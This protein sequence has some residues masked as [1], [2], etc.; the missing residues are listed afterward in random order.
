MLTFFLRRLLQLCCFSL[1]IMLL[2]RTCPQKFQRHLNL[3][4]RINP[5][6]K[7]LLLKVLMTCDLSSLVIV[8][9]VICQYS[10]SAEALLTL[11][12]WNNCQGTMIFLLLEWKRLC[13]VQDCS[14]IGAM[15]LT[16]CQLWRCLSLELRTVSNGT[17]NAN[18]KQV[19]DPTL[20]AC[21][22]FV[23]G[24]KLLCNEVAGIEAATHKQSGSE[25]WHL[26]RN[27][28]L[29]SSRFGECQLTTDSWR[30]VQDIMGYDGPPN[31]AISPCTWAQWSLEGV[32]NHQLPF[33]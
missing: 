14:T 23:V 1:N 4:L 33:S 28:R 6:R 26:M 32:T 20:I 22:Q 17:V 16:Q 19:A 2:M 13:H 8:T 10:V 12:L 9:V 18:T 30:L 11:K 25:F 29:T 5:P 24:I 15:I 21:H 31:T 27:S 3:W 7:R